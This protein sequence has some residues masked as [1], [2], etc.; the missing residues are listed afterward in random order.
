MTNNGRW[1][2]SSVAFAAVA[3]MA[4]MSGFMTQRR[5]V[6]DLTPARLRPG[7]YVWKRIFLGRGQRY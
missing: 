2:G 7:S 4:M 3:Q 5:L 1:K 6:I